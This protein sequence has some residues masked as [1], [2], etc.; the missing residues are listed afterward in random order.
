[1][2]LVIGLTGPNAAGKGEVAAHLASLG[3]KV[4]SLSD[5]VREEAARQDLPPERAN[6]IRI[7]NGLRRQGGAGVL[8]QRILSR[9]EDRA[10]VVSGTD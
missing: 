7:G 1:M 8:A 2:N 5:V 3:F 6:L 10:V 4:H 9:L